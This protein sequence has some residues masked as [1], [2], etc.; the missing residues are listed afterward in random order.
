MVFPTYV[1]LEKRS[2][3]RFSQASL[4]ATVIYT[5]GFIIVG[6]CGLLLFGSETKPDLLLN[7]GTRPG[8]ISILIRTSYCAV[9]IL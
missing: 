6:V 9:L 7:I 1:E 4:L 5:S 2:N 3:D 8:I